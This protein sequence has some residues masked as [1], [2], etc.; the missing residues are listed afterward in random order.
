MNYQQL[1][2]AIDAAAQSLLGQAAQA[3]NQAL[4]LRN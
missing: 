3:V 4:V 2:A 1:V